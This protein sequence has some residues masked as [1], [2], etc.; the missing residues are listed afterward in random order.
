MDPYLN[1]P[2]LIPGANPEL[3][4]LFD[5]GIF[6]SSPTT[7]PTGT[8]N[9]ISARG[10]DLDAQGAAQIQK[11]TEAGASMSEAGTFF[12][13]DNPYGAGQ[14]R[15]PTVSA[16]E[17]KGI[18]DTFGL[19]GMGLDKE[20]V[21]MTQAQAT[22][23]AME[24]KRERMGQ[25][26][27]LTSFGFRPET[28]SGFRDV[29]SQ[30][31]AQLDQTKQAPWVDKETKIEQNQNLLNSYTSQFASLFNTPQEFQAAQGDPEFANL[32]KQ[33]ERSGGSRNAIAANIGQT[34][35]PQVQTQEQAQQ[36]GYQSI[37]QYLGAMDSQAKQMA[38]QTLI[39]EKQ[40]AQDQ[41]AFEQSIPE[42]YKQDYF[43]SP[44]QVGLLERKIVESNEAIKIT[45]RRAQAEAQNARAM[46]ELTSE[47][48]R[49]EMDRTSAEIEKNRLTAKNY[50]IG[51]LAKLGALKTTGAAP[52]AIANLEQKYQQQSQE[53]R[54]TYDMANR[55]LDIRL[56][57][58]I[59][60]I[61]IGRDEDIL[62][63]KQDLTKSEESVWQ[64]IFKLQ[65][66]AQRNEFKIIDGF[67][68]DFRNQ[69]SKYETELKRE[70]EK[71]AK[72]LA[73]AAGKFDAKMSFEQFID[74]KQNQ[75]Q[76]T[77]PKNLYGNYREE[78]EKV[79]KERTSGA[80]TGVPADV[81][82]TSAEK[83]VDT[84]KQ[85]INELQTLSKRVNKETTSDEIQ[86]LRRAFLATYPTKNA[87]FNQYLGL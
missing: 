77:I 66:T 13:Q 61:E 75:L 28:I 51:Q 81:L 4:R 62:K 26:S 2:R 76:R 43:G 34:Q 85:M 6:N 79:N 60:N 84:E 49:I 25:V 48:G 71:Y 21:G 32:L 8:N 11:A 33:Y 38:I 24:L 45:E 3:L 22:Q 54:T 9:A 36:L 56:R 65:I 72:E 29:F 18:A 27:S 30:L 7:A 69:T 70:A 82:P 67:A 68:R 19:S 50:M 80:K 35:Q 44:E 17:A 86:R 10:E 52:E 47:K 73:K 55:E 46:A 16:F 41:I 64:E 42:A 87:L 58:T 15:Q 14:W 74:A 57:D 63:I 1:D 31:N 39:P 78:F 40:V 23:R 59:N 12:S 37:D 5:S 83:E 53:L 20:F